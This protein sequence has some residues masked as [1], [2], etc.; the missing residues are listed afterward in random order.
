MIHKQDKVIQLFYQKYSILNGGIKGSSFF[1]CFNKSWIRAA[2]KVFPAWLNEFCSHQ[3]NVKGQLQQKVWGK[4]FY[5]QVFH[6]PSGFICC[7]NWL[8]M[9]IRGTYCNTVTASQHYAWV[10][11]WAQHDVNCISNQLE[12]TVPSLDCAHNKECTHSPKMLSES[13]LKKGETVK[14]SSSPSVWQGLMKHLYQVLFHSLSN[15]LMLVS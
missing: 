5:W 1:V 8:H 9:R 15:Q 12:H 10:R 14:P 4:G 3:S 7:D 2:K 13:W 11:C 6:F